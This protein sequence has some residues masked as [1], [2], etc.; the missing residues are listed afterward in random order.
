MRK[1]LPSAVVVAMM[2][3]GWLGAAR[4]ADYPRNEVWLG[5]GGATGFENSILNLPNDVASQPDIAVSFGFMRNLSA[6]S[7]IGIYLYGAD[8]TTPGAG[9]SQLTLSSGNLGVRYRHTFTRRAFAPYL[10][11]GA[12]LSAA[13]LSGGSAGENSAT[14]FSVSLGPGV[15]I[16]LGRHFLVSAEGIASLGVAR[17]EKLPAAASSDRDFNPSLLGGT[18]NLGYAWGTKPAAKPVPERPT[19]PDSSRVA[20]LNADSSRT[21]PSIGRILLLEGVIMLHSSAAYA[22]DKG[23]LLAGITAAAALLGGAAG[24]TKAPSFKVAFFGMLSLAAVE[25][26]LGQVGVSEDGLFATSM[27]G[28]NVIA[29]AANRAEEKARAR[30]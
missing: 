28:L 17:W 22:G 10:F 24:G 19:G 30:Q 15:G 16:R 4:A 25:V 18:I 6:R 5:A 29:L 3:A 27:V 23:G 21:G 2:L 7:A 9:G 14:G 26:T 20:G 12:G 8:E 13:E 1:H 11:A